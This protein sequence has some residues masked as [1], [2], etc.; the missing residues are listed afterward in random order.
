MLKSVYQHT[1]KTTFAIS[2]IG[3]HSGA[4]AAMT[5]RPAPASSG[6]VFIRT[7]VKGRSNVIPARWN[8]VTETRLCTVLANKAGVSVSTVEHLLSAFAALGVDNAM[9]EIDGPEV[10]IMDGSAIC[11]VRALDKTGLT[12]QNAHRHALRIKKTVSCRE[13]DK[14]VFLSP[15]E[16]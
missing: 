3:V 7:D 14:A 13:G 6:I 10:P 11:F 15:A 9:V 2:G 1:V 16:G 4:A 5:I 8:K 12:R